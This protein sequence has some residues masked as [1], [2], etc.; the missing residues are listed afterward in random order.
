MTFLAAEACHPKVADLAG[1]LCGPGQVV[2][3]GRGTAARIN[4]TVDDRWRARGLKELF[5]ERGVQVEVSVTED[6]RFQV[7]TPFRADLT[8][9]ASRWL[10][11]EGKTVPDGFEFD[12]HTLRF[13]ALTSGKFVPGGY[14]FGL[15]PLA[16]ET[17]NPL[18]EALQRIGQAAR[19]LAPRG[20]VPGLRVAGARRLARLADLVGPIPVGVE[21]EMW[22]AA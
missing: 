11:P 3:F 2:G 13:W 15:D 22:P 10:R 18:R 5:A 21:Q 6:G 20:E 17:H 1:L 4:V 16:P 9:L 8:R 14:L 7:R 19:L 12:G